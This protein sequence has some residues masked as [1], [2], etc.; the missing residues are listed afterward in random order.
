MVIMRRVVARLEYMFKCLLCISRI[1]HS[2]NVILTFDDTPEPG[3]KEFVLNLLRDYN[4]KA[5]FFCV[6]ETIQKYE[7]VSLVS[8][9]NLG[10]VKH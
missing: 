10:L 4:V 2:K 8:H 3:I 7:G 1:S 9:K 5:T 6:G